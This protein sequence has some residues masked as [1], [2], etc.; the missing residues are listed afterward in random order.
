MSLKRALFADRTLGGSAEWVEEKFCRLANVGA[1]WTRN[2]NWISLYPQ[3]GI[4]NQ[5]HEC[6][7]KKM[8]SHKVKLYCCAQTNIYICQW[9]GHFI[10]KSI[11]NFTCSA[12]LAQMLKIQS[13][14][15][16]ESA[17]TGSDFI[18]FLHIDQSWYL[19]A[20][21]WDVS[22]LDPQVKLLQ[23]TNKR[24]LAKTIDLKRK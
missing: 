22:Q 21:R 15:C 3:F 14:Y 1:D 19:G 8:S 4:I 17:C 2:Q 23:K 9:A 13:L 12:H 5:S 10:L 24:A 18:F 20:D 7:T 16:P 11:M 6:L